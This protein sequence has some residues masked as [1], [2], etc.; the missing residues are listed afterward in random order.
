[1]RAFA[2]T[3]PQVLQLIARSA[4]ANT[5]RPSISQGFIQR[6]LGAA[7][8]AQ[9]SA[10]NPPSTTVTAALSAFLTPKESQVLQLLAAGLPNMR[11]ASTLG[12]SNETIKW[13]MKKL[14][15][16]LNA[17]NRQHAVHRARLLG[18]LS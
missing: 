1:V 11:I 9:P 15:T 8:S 16:K 3:L 4:A 2:E 13:H 18:L 10:S 6:L 12:L 7:E 17:G 14:F 5:L